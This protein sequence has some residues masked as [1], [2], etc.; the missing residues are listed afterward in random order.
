QATQDTDEWSHYPSH[1]VKLDGTL[2]ITEKFASTLAILYNSPIKVDSPNASVS[3]DWFDHHRIVVNM[4]GT[5]HGTR[6]YDVSLGVTNLFEQG[7]PPASFSNLQPE[8][9]LVGE[10]E[11]RIHLELVWT[12][13]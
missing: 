2:E 5:Y 13:Q 10:N 3:G 8:V 1:M 11:R 9:S 6:G 12:S 7:T 4:K